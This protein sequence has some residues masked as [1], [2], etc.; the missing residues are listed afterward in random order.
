MINGCTKCKHHK[1]IND[2]DPH[3]SFCSDDVAVVCTLVK[4]KPNL[5]SEYKVDHQEYK[6]CT[7]GCRPYNITKETTPIPSWCPISNKKILKKKLN[8]LIKS[9][10]SK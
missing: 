3:D 5:K 9:E 10:K 6:A 1:V 7:T 8:I 2:G 4:R